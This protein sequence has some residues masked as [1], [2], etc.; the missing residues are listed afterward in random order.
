MASSAFAA[1]VGTWGNVGGVG[2][3][4]MWS[5]GT[6]WAT[7]T[8]GTPPPTTAAT[9]DEIKITPSNSDCTIDYT[10]DYKCRVTIGGGPGD[11]NAPV[12]RVVKDADFGTGELRVGARGATATGSIGKVIQTGGKLSVTDLIIGRFGTNTFTAQGYYTISGGTLTAKTGSN[13]R[14]YVGAGTNTGYTEGT[15]TVENGIAVDPTITMKKL[16]VGSDGTNSG[17][18]TL[19]FK[20]RST[21][22]VDPIQIS[23]ATNGN[24]DVYL[25]K[26]GAASTTLLALSLLSEPPPN[27][28]V[29][30]KQADNGVV[31]GKFDNVMDLVGDNMYS[32]V[33]GTTIQLAFGA[34]SYTYMLTY[35]FNSDGTANDIALVPE[36]ATVAL[37][38]LGALLAV[39]R[40]RKR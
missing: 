11:A 2:K 20:I 9:G 37:L 30:V 39:R 10:A 31:D 17:K 28:I 23:D 36:P 24:T 40:P 13:G 25:D 7:T 6:M 8:Y 14:M 33:E 35:K 15:F 22:G 18:G 19:E 21:G 27:V 26:G 32:G 3:V 34:N 1:T 38:G 16:Y 5:D 12:V 29:L 4:G